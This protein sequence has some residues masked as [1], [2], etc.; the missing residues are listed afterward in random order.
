[1]AV[2]K[3][4]MFQLQSPPTRVP[5]EHPALNILVLFDN[6]GNTLLGGEVTLLAT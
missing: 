6:N 1:V 5:A 4:N 3:E 2:L